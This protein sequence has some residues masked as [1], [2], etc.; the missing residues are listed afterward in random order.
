MEAA[1]TEP[2][3]CRTPNYLGMKRPIES[4]AAAENQLWPTADRL[5]DIRLISHQRPFCSGQ[6]FV[7]RHYAIR[8]F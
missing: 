7:T 1:S 4:V 2:S 5:E 8:F 6:R 3:L